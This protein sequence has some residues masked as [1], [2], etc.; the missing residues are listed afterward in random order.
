MAR[1]SLLGTTIRLGAYG[2]AAVAAAGGLY[3]ARLAATTTVV[4]PLPE[5]DPIWS[6]EIYRRLNTFGNPCVQDKIV[7][8]VPLTKIRPE[9]LETEGALVTELNRGLWGGAGYT[10][11]RL[12]LARSLRNEQTADQLWTRDELVGSDYATGTRHTDHFE[13]VS[14]T[15][16]E[17]LFR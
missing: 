4:T 12:L 17:I 3:A 7:K 2:A 15:S 6:T 9:L 8:R 5:D 16:D 11:Q 13:V 14:K 1:R 10:P